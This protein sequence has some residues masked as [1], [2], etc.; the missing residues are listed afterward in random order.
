MFTMRGLWKIEVII[1][2]G[3]KKQSVFFEVGL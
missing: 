2:R 1:E 3:G